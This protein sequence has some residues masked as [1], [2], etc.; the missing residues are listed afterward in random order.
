VPAREPV[1]VVTDAEGLP[2]PADEWSGDRE[3]AVPRRRQDWR[4]LVAIF[5]LTSVVEGIGVS[6]I[7]AFVPSYLLAMGVP[8]AE[9]FRFVGLFGSLIF[10]VGAPLVPLSLPRAC[11]SSASSSGTRASCSPRSAT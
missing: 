6:Q 5:C 9:R 4:I 7:Y 2:E 11:S 10:V 8:D 3:S 1:E